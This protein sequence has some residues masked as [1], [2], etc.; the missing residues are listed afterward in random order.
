M[1]AADP[2]NWRRAYPPGFAVSRWTAPDG[3]VLRR[4]DWPAGRPRG[5]LIFQVGRGDIF[6]KY[7][8]VLAYWHQRGWS[9][10]GFDWRGHGG[11]G[12]FDQAAPVPSQFAPALADLTAQWHAWA[13][14]APQPRVLVGHSM[15]GYLSLRAALDGA[16]APDALV[17]VAPMLGLRSPV[18]AQA[19]ERLCGWL[20]ATGMRDVAAP[21]VDRMAHLTADAARYADEAWWHARLPEHRLGPP[22]W[23]WLHEAFAATRR[24]RADSRL[25]AL[26]VPTLMLVADRDRLVDAA[27]ARAV[28]AR[29]PAGELASFPDAAHE[30]LREVDRVRDRALA[31]IDAFLHRVAP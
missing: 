5:T 30:I 3:W 28:A 17:L 23:R 14:V 8:E 13:A 6:E 16:I 10:A 20:A 12:R 26:G 24:L 2:S 22:T 4:F 31:T 29:L 19:G 7:L 9:L 25:A 1:V 27:A 21:P 15:G 18:G 11:S